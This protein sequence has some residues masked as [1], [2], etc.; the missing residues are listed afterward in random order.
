MAYEKVYGI[1]SQ[2]G[3]HGH[4]GCPGCGECI[5]DTLIAAAMDECEIKPEEVAVASGTG[6]TGMGYA[7]SKKGCGNGLNRMNWN[8]FCPPHGRAAAAASAIKRIHPE[9]FILSIQGDG[10]LAGI[11]LHETINAANR[12]ECIS[13]FFGN[14]QVYGTTGGQMAPT[15]LVEQVTTTSPF[16][17]DPKTQG[18]PLHMCEMLA[19]LQGVKYCARV[20]LT[21]A[22][23]IMF[24]RKCIKKAIECQK[25]N[26]GYAFVECLSAC[27]SNW[28]MSPEQ[29]MKHID[30]VVIQEFPIG[31]FKTY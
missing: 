10:D 12:G 23:N 29:C 17:R 4:M 30:E 6:C 21:D 28:H 22:K 5:M 8:L 14:N 7:S 18:Y 15:T 27:P 1:P 26:I 24:A 31:E 3:N 19:P 20:T 9:K 16:G 13:V 2:E 25:N 11:G